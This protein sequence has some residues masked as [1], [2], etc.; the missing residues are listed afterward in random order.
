MEKGPVLGPQ[1]GETRG[2]IIGDNSPSG[3]VKDGFRKSI[4]PGMFGPMCQWE[5]IK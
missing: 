4:I 2:C 1:N 5:P 3:T